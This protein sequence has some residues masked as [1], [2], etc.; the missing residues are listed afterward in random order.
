MPL[1]LALAL[2]ALLH[3]AAI[4]APGWDLPG[5]VE[6][7]PAVI[8]AQLAKPP[9]AAGVAA[10]KSKPR[11]APARKAVPAPVRHDVVAAA[12]DAAPVAAP[13]PTVTA[14]VVPEPVASA[15]LPAEPVA[16]AAPPPPAPPWPP[17]GRI[18]YVV[19]YGEGGMVVGQTVQEWQVDGAHYTLR[20]LAEPKGL[21]AMFGKT[22][23]QE[24][25]GVVTIAGLRP[26][27]FRDQR[28]GRA[29]EAVAF[30]WAAGRVVFSGGRGA[31]SLA[32]GTQDLISVFYQLAWLPPGRDA[33]LS[34]ATASRVGRWTFEWVGVETLAVGARTLDTQHWRTR[35]DGDATEVWLAPAHGGLPVKIRHSDRKGDVFEQVADSIQLD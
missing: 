1:A 4:S 23:A 33:V 24:S 21:A 22:R 14:P 5:I 26:E 17:R 12:A 18:S 10:E 7:E 29:Q 19:T 8:E 30:D 20:S 11:V 3:A 31:V 27:E 28:E 15:P 32:E 9:K 2:S 34:V 25:V 6:P 16:V 13:G 35:A